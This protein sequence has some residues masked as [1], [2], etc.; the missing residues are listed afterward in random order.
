MKNERAEL[1]DLCQHIADDL[2][3]IYNGEA[4]NE[5]GEEVNFWDYLADALDVEYTIGSDKAYRGARIAVTL[6]GPNIY[7]DTRR[8]EVKGFWGTERAAAWIPSEICAELDAVM[9][10][11]YVCLGI[12]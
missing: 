12:G 7:I 9:E 11:Y 5:D 2:K 6:G 10:E 8:G 4:T 1:Q 3:A